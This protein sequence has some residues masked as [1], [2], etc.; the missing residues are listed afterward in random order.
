MQAIPDDP[1]VS[2]IERTGYPPWF[3]VDSTLEEEVDDDELDWPQNWRVD[4]GGRSPALSEV[5]R[6]EAEDPDE[7]PSRRV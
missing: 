2:C 6:G 3:M 5:C 1:I 7:P 4:R